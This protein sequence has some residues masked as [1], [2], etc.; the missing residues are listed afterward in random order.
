MRKF[1]LEYYD[2]NCANGWYWHLRNTL[3]IKQW[4]YNIEIH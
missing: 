2:Y 3:K 4:R 1:I